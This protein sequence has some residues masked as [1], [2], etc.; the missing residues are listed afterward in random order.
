MTQGHR[1]TSHM[2]LPGQP[3]PRRPGLAPGTSADSRPGHP[4]NTADRRPEIRFTDWA[5]I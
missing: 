5:L 3:D 4:R 1:P 2:A